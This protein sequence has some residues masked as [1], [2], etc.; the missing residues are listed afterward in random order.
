MKKEQRDITLFPTRGQPSNAIFYPES[1]TRSLV[2]TALL[3]WVWFSCHAASPQL[4][5]QTQFG[6]SL[7]NCPA[8]ALRDATK[9]YSASPGGR[10]FRCVHLPLML[11][12]G[13]QEL[14]GELV[15]GRVMDRRNEAPGCVGLFVMFAC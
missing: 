6:Q 8:A 14:D 4:Q 2:L 7:R 5:R 11:S 13:G 15:G 1:A 3:I 12:N 10:L 9:R